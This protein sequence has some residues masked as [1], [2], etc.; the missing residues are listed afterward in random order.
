MWGAEK[1][2]PLFAWREYGFAR[3]TKPIARYSD[4]LARLQKTLIIPGEQAG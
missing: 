4:F 3:I 2:F 1:G